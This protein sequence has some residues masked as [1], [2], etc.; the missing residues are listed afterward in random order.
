[1]EKPKIPRTFRVSF[2]CPED[3]YQVLKRVAFDLSTSVPKVVEH[4]VVSQ[5]NDFLFLNGGFE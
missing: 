1:M 2:N 4:V 5:V 3:V